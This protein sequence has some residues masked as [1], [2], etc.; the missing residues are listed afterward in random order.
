MTR[1]TQEGIECTQEFIRRMNSKGFSNREITLI[2]ITEGCPEMLGFF[3][4][5]E[6]TTAQMEERS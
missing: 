3:D 5:I 6:R 2:V 4:D 1:V